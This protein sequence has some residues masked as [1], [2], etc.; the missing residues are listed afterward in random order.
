MGPHLEAGFRQN[1]EHLPGHRPFRGTIM[2]ARLEEPSPITLVALD[3]VGCDEE[4]G[5]SPMLIEDG[6]DQI[7]V[8]KESVVEGEGYEPAVGWIARADK[9]DGLAH[10]DKL[11]MVAEHAQGPSEGG[12]F[13]RLHVMTAEETDHPRRNPNR[14]PSCDAQRRVPE[15]LSYHL[16]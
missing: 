3:E 16:R 4:A 5:A 12:G 7:E 6:G 15:C 10:R 9:V 11:E 2:R 14:D 8:V 13:V 1:A